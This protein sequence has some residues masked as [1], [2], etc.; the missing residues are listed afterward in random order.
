M[1]M[2]TL[3]ITI[4][5]KNVYPPKS[6]DSNSLANTLRSKSPSMPIL[7]IVISVSPTVP[8]G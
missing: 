7:Y 6:E 2:S 4:T 8:K 1:A 3:V 5:T